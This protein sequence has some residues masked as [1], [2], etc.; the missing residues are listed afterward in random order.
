MAKTGDLEERV[1][2]LENRYT[3]AVTI[4][5]VLGI[6]VGGLSLGVRDATS[7]VSAMHDQIAQMQP[8]VDK[9]E[10]D[11]KQASQ[12]QIALIHSQAAPIVHDL[13]EQNLK[14]ANIQMGRL[15]EDLF[16]LYYAEVVYP[17]QRTGSY[18]DM[19]NN[20]KNTIESGRYGRTKEELEN[21]SVHVPD[22]Y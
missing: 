15:Q 19:V 10:T 3:A 22:H 9:A 4:A 16:Y 7:R 21:A 11:L 6:S 5:A 17:P 12:D 2:K 20:R 18:H 1:R 14:A 8:I 13:T